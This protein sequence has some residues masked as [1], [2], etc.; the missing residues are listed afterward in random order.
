MD[1]IGT[2]TILTITAK[3]PDAI[4]RY[5]DAHMRHMVAW[6]K[7]EALDP[8]SGRHHLAHAGCNVIFLLYLEMNQA[9]APDEVAH[10]LGQCV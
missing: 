2:T 8:E 10:I 9:E 7:G 3:V 5:F 6:R 1:S 4:D